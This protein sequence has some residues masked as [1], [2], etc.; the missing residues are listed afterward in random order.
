M[1]NWFLNNVLWVPGIVLLLLLLLLCVEVFRG[2]ER[3]LWVILADVDYLGHNLYAIEGMRDTFELD[4]GLHVHE[5]FE[6]WRSAF[7]NGHVHFY[8]PIMFDD[9]RKTFLPINPNT[10]SMLNKMADIQESIRKGDKT[11]PL[12]LINNRR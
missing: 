11:L 9:L 5:G 4:P 10:L 1:V 8:G 7:F 2:A 3:D 6:Q 12:T